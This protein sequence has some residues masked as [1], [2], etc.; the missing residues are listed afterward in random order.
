MA[1]RGITKYDTLIGYEAY[2]Y[3]PPGTK[4]LLKWSLKSIKGKESESLVD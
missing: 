2:S 3:I 1:W 4:L